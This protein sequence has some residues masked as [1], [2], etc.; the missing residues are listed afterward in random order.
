M[1]AGPHE[2]LEPAREAIERRACKMLAQLQ[3]PAKDQPAK[4][5]PAADAAAKGAASEVSAAGQEAG[6]GA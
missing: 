2:I 4:D 6:Q 3:E 1:P 5:Q